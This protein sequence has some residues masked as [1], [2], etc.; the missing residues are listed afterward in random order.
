MNMKPGEWV[1]ING[2]LDCIATTCG[3][4][5]Q[6]QKTGTSPSPTSTG[7][8]R[9]GFVMSEM[10]MASGSPTWM[11]APW[12]EGNLEVTWTA[13][14]TLSCGTALMLTTVGPENTP[15]AARIDGG[16]EHGDVPSGLNVGQG[17]AGAYQGVLEGE[18]APQQEGDHVAG[19]EVGDAL[20][21]VH[22]LT[23][24]VDLIPGQV[25]R[26]IGTGGRDG[27]LDRAR[28]HN[29]D[30]GT[31]LG[32]PLAEEEEVEGLL[33]RQHDEVRLH[34]SG[35]ESRGRPDQ[36]AFPEHASQLGRAG[37]L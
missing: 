15:A 10:P 7:S 37:G 32:V 23:P 13:L 14:T 33:L 28:L 4:T 17:D 27:R 16:D 34:V 25:A 22:H 35:S 36:G 9:S 5:P 31:W 18:A 29:L 8:P 1:I 12:T 6:A 26:E 19:P 2:G 11:G 30:E 24:L 20:R 21:L 3:V